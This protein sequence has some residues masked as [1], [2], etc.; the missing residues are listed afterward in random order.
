MLRVNFADETH[1]IDP[2]IVS[3]ACVGIAQSGCATAPAKAQSPEVIVGEALEQVRQALSLTKDPEVSGGH[4]SY[5]LKDRGIWIS[6]DTENKVYTVRLDAPYAAPV[7]GIRIGDSRAALDES[8][9]EPKTTLPGVVPR[10]VYIYEFEASHQVRY[11]FDATDKVNTIFILSNNT[12][13][14]QWT[15]PPR[16][17]IR[18]PLAPSAPLVRTPPGNSLSPDEV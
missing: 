13:G 17:P 14:S 6:L 8:L 11:D 1:W 10:G 5:R 18:V 12:T 2:G 9:G 7:H 15:P 3:L 4:S 16:V